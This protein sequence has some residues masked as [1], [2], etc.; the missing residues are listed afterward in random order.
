MALSKFSG[1]SI[2]VPAAFMAGA[3]DWGIYQF[4]GAFEKMQTQACSDMRFCELIPGAGHWVQQEQAQRVNRRLLDF[5][6]QL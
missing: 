5:L 6:N 2:Q 4:P 3:S 1:Q